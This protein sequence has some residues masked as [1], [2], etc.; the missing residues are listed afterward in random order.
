MQESGQRH[1]LAALL[2]GKSPRYPLDRRL[3]GPQ[4]RSGRSGVENIFLPLPGNESR[5]QPVAVL[6]ELSCH[7]LNFVI[8]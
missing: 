3:A 5:V 6:T 1:A 4:S 2:H 8:I 7:D